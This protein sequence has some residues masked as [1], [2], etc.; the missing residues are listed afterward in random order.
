MAIRIVTDSM[1]SIPP[2]TARALGITVVPLIVFFG[3]EAYLD[4]V[5]L[6]ITGFYYKL[7]TSKIFPHTSLPPPATFQQ[8]YIRLIEEGADAILSIHLSSKL[9]S[10]YQSAWAAREMLP[11][12]V[13]KIPIEL[14]DSQSASIG[15]LPAILQAAREAREGL[16]LEEIKS[17]LLDLLSRTQ[18]LGVLDTLEFVKRGGRVNGALARLGGMLS[19][20]PLLSLKNGEIIPVGVSRTRSGAYTRIAQLVTEMGEVEQ[21]VA[22]ESSQGVGQQLIE[23]LKVTYQGDIPLYQ[24]G[25]VLGAHTGPGTTAVAVVSAKL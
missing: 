3:D 25:V 2:E 5:E 16:E 4:N 7:R 19:V 14:V 6:D 9:S 8:A 23:V 12:E 20:K 13:K 15:M 1:A 24:L 22:G 18:F 17:H 21:I 10:T 11:D